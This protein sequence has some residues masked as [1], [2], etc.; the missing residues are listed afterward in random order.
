[1]ATKVPTIGKPN[2][3]AIAGMDARDLFEAR[4]F[5]IFALVQ[6]FRAKDADTV[7]AAAE[8]ISAMTSEMRMRGGTKGEQM[9]S[10]LVTP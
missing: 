2:Y 9:A 10:L 7:Q 6:A 4:E 1:M 3:R 8:W 5:Y